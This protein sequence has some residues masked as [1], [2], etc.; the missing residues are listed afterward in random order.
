MTFETLPR[1]TADV[2]KPSGRTTVTRGGI[3]MA[4]GRVTD[5]AQSLA[6]GLNTP[7]ST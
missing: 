2:A 5:W 6:I 4:S 7:T 3:A 1:A